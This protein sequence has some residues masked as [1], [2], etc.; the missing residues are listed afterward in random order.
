MNNKMKDSKIEWIGFIPE[1]WQIKKVKNLFL[2]RKEVNTEDDPV[3]LSL[4][5]EGVKVRDISNNEG[6][7]A[8]NYSNYHCVYKGDLLINPMDL[9]S[10][11]N[12]SISEV[13]GVISPA[14]I[15]LASEADVD[16]KYYD[17]FFKTQYWSNSMF[18]HGKGVSFE[19]RWTINNETLMNYYVP[20]PKLIDQKRISGFLENN[21]EKINKF[22][23]DNKKHITLMEEYKKSL[24]TKTVTKGLKKNPK[25]LNS[26]VEWMGKIPAHWGSKR[27]KF[28]CDYYNGV[29]HEK[30]QD[31]N[32]EFI[33]VNSKFVSTGGKVKKYTNNQGFPLYKDDICI[34]LSDLPNGRALARTYIIDIDKKYTL[35]QRVG[36]LRKCKITPKY[37]SYFMNRNQTLLDYNDGA[38][39]TNLKKDHVLNCKILLPPIDEQIEIIK[40]LDNNCS[41]I[42]EIIEYRKQVTEKLEEYK[43]S[44]IYEAVTGKIEVQ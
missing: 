18:I 27:L 4:S 3:I 20:F 11:A 16:S 15:N 22:I 32:G 25:L 1:E 30:E 2:R 6:Q 26:G 31:F 35:N 13:E 44:L 19:N 34:V 9:V 8:E 29:G 39:Q 37:L 28:L 24:I 38:N 23:I 36:V 17:Y 5:R 43:K 7:L 21:I 42:E 40:Y 33:L 14:Y 41:K 12:C 10:G